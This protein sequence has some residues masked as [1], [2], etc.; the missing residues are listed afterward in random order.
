M[1]VHIYEALLLHL[2]CLALSQTRRVVREETSGG[3]AQFLMGKECNT[4]SDFIYLLRSDLLA[5]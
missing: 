1:Y 3:L 2:S 5:G 4:R